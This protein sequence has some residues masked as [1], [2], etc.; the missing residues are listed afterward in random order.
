MT[1]THHLTGGVQLPSML[2]PRSF[3]SSAAPS[4]TL[5]PDPKDTPMP[6]PVEAYKSSDGSLFESL[7]AAERHEHHLQFAKWYNESQHLL[8]S[9][10]DPGHVI[11]HE[12]TLIDWLTQHHREVIQFLDGPLFP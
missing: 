3:A 7:Y 4:K 1:K 6:Q 9:S 10:T 8:C 12:S 11:V 2:S 5:L